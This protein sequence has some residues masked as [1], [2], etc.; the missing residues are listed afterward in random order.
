MP[1]FTVCP[2]GKCGYVVFWPR[3]MVCDAGGQLVLEAVR[4]VTD[5]Y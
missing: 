2:A 4:R 5:V 3:V 1:L